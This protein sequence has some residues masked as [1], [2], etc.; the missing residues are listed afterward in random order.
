M[1]YQELKHPSLEEGALLNSITDSACSTIRL[2]VNKACQLACTWC[3]EEGIDH[4]N[5]K[6]VLT[7]ETFVR[8]G[9]VASKRGFSTMTFSGGE[10]LL[11]PDLFRIQ[12]SAADN[13]MKT[14]VT[15]NGVSIERSNAVEQWKNIPNHEVHIS[16]NTVDEKE[17]RSITRRGL[18]K[19]VLRGITR[20]V[21]AG[22]PLKF[23]TVVSSESDWPKVKKVIDFAGE[24]GVVVKLLGVHDAQQQ[25]FFQKNVAEMILKNGAEY[26]ARS[27]GG[28]VNYGYEQFLVN[29][30]RVHVLDMIYGGG[31]CDRFQADQCGEGIRY[32]RI[33]Y[34]GE[35]KPCLHQ[36]IGSISNESSDLEIANLL[37]ESR[38]YIRNLAQKPFYLDSIK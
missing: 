24:I 33:V 10:P 14:Y 18:L 15:T 12:K 34:T 21:D 26:V 16:L 25:P 30:T 19:N 22:I 5:S 31:C 1:E 3:Y 38:R 37:E 36:G 20:L 32:P 23:N 17:Y 13:G 29:K 8:V 4:K 35:V 6:K 28:E 27:E 9:A 11:Y 2:V 7:P